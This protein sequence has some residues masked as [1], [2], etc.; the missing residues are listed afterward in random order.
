MEVEDSDGAVGG[1]VASSQT[2]DVQMEAQPSTSGTATGT[3]ISHRSL[4]T[5]LRCESE[6][7]DYPEVPETAPW[8]ASVPNGWI[9]TLANDVDEQRKIVSKVTS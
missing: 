7:E 1:A 4:L 3:T 2:Q 6:C 5:R 8:H 9:N